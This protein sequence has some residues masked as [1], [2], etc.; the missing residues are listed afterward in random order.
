MPKVLV[1]GDVIDDILV[2]PKGPIRIDTDTNADIISHPGGSGANFACWLASCGVETS[3]VGRVGQADVSRQAAIL[4]S[5]G[6]KPF[7]QGDEDLQTGKIVVLV[8]GQNRSFL[9]DRGAN[10]NLDLAQIPDELFGDALYISG[11]SVFDQNLLRIQNLI[12][13][14]R[15][16]GVVICDPGSAGYISDHN[17]N[18][19]LAAINGVDIL[20]PSLEEGRVLTSED[21][22]E[23]IAGQLAARFSLVALTLGERGVQLAWGENNLRVN[24]FDADLVDATG[25]GDAF[26]AKFLTGLL[27]M[28]EPEV[29]ATEANR[30][31]AKAVASI[32][33]RPKKG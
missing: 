13:R 14:A 33:G 28:Q 15:A 23:H 22:P 27:S 18:A 24:G 25:A 21:R 7:L 4:E 16:R 26:A 20:V 3:F 5:Y 29:A 10:K 8:E 2:G 31:A 30:M 9:T 1:V 32:G 6:V 17:V 19:F 12:S 11:Y